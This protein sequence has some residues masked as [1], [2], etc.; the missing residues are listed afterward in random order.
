MALGL[1]KLC[2]IAVLVIQLTSSVDAG[3]KISCEICRPIVYH[4]KIP[5]TTTCTMYYT[6]QQVA[7]KRSTVWYF[8]TFKRIFR[9]SICD[10]ANNRRIICC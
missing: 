4:S 7:G 2:L 8:A 6:M 3:E 9:L 1:L 5:K 10:N